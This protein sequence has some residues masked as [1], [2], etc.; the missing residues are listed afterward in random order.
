MK[1]KKIIEISACISEASKNEKTRLLEQIVAEVY[2][3]RDELKKAIIDC[4]KNKSF[5]TLTLDFE[6]LS[7]RLLKKYRLY[8]LTDGTLPL[9]RCKYCGCC[10]ITYRSY[11]YRDNNECTSRSYECLTC[12]DF[13]N[14]DVQD[15]YNIYQKSGVR[16]AKK[17]QLKLLKEDSIEEPIV[18]LDIVDNYGDCSILLDTYYLA[19]PDEEKLQELKSMVENRYKDKKSGKD[20]PFAYNYSG[21]KDYVINNFRTIDIETREVKW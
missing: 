14:E 16:E 15:I 1:E 13:R 18:R 20:N 4:D 19:N 11:T 2:D 3:N 9:K 7:K 21:V 10:Y 8:L 5:V 6:K 17:Y 12:R